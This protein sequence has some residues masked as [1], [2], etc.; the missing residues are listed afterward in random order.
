M[1][2]TSRCVALL[3]L[4]GLAVVAVPGQTTGYIRGTVVDGDGN[5]LEGVKVEATS[6]TTGSRFTTTGKD[7]L[8][9]FAMIPPGS[10][11]V[12]FTLDSYADVEKNALV[13]L[14]GT[15]TVNAKLFRI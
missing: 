8:F 13:K 6:A 1:R 5:A 12:R 7:G 15:T 2:W 4:F 14:D 10:Y 9:R 11:T 3:L